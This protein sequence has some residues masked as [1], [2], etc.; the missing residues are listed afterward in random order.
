MSSM[1]FR[2]SGSPTAHEHAEARWMVEQH[3]EHPIA[4]EIYNNVEAK[5]REHH[6]QVAFE[7]MQPLELGEVCLCRSW[8][9]GLWRCC[10]QVAA[11]RY[12]WGDEFYSQPV[13]EVLD[14]GAWPAC[15][16]I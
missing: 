7:R 15:L 11:G 1:V 9:H 16:H 13:W 12:A 3:D 14:G 6:E 2:I 8:P 4:Y 10:A 5:S